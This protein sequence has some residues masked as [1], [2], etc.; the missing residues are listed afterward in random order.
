MSLRLLY[1]DVSYA[2]EVHDWIIEQSGGLAGTR[3]IGQLKSPLEHIQNDDYYP[4]IEDKLNR[5]RFTR[6]IFAS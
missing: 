4:E 3:D 2:I 1:F 5:P 6:H